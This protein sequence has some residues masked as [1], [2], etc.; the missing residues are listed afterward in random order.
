MTTWEMAT[1]E[2]TMAMMAMKLHPRPTATDGR[3]GGGSGTPWSLCGHF[4][5]ASGVPDEAKKAMNDTSECR[6][7]L[8]RG[9]GGIRGLRS[10][11]ISSNDDPRRFGRRTTNDLPAHND[12]DGQRPTPRQY[13]TCLPVAPD[14]WGGSE[15][16]IRGLRPLA[17]FLA[18]TSASLLRLGSRRMTSW[19]TMTRTDDLPPLG[20]TTRAS[21]EYRTV[22]REAEGAYEGISTAACWTCQVERISRPR[23]GFIGYVREASCLGSPRVPS[24]TDSSSAFAAGGFLPSIVW[25]LPSLSRRARVSE[26]HNG[27]LKSRQGQGRVARPLAS[28]IA[29]VA[30]VIST[31]ESGH[32]V[33]SITAVLIIGGRLADR[34]VIDRRNAHGQPLEWACGR[35]LA[36]RR[37][38]GVVHAPERH[39]VRPRVVL[40]SSTSSRSHGVT[41]AG[42]GPERKAGPPLAQR[43]PFAL[44]RR[45]ETPHRGSAP[46]T[47]S[48]RNETGGPR[49]GGAGRLRG[50]RRCTHLLTQKSMSNSTHMAATDH[51]SSVE[52]GAESTDLA[53]GNLQERLMASGHE[54]PEEDRCPICLDLIE[55]PVPEHSAT[56]VCCMKKVCNGC[57]LEA[58]WRG[59]LDSCPFCRTKVPDND[60]SSLAMMQKRA[61]KKD[62]EAIYQL[63]NAYRQ[64][65]FGM[66]KDVP[67]A[68]E[69]WTE[70]AE[71]GS[72]DAHYMLGR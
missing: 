18:M 65:H 40:W 3:V 13:H 56:N 71:L 47:R 31:S 9:V 51:P 37:G 69:M 22:K 48:E 39:R 64:G 19:P 4:P 60:A 34:L 61:D 63:G 57:I 49:G 2:Q 41:L 6:G 25:L 55:F 52:S 59:M 58:R 15:R 67:R 70:A 23:A 10:G 46:D 30:P 68:I 45:N 43:R 38:H 29:V 5:R 17:T 72:L 66:V 33:I 26:H 28:V 1:F 21:L 50:R 12:E 44:H 53:A 11:Y 54:R 14:G 27:R 62:A 36:R 32:G 42:P 35:R 7:G 24:N 16:G 8:E 20:D